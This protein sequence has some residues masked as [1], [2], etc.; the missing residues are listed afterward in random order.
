MRKIGFCGPIV[1]SA[2]AWCFA[3]ASENCVLLRQGFGA[4]SKKISPSS[5]NKRMKPLIFISALFLF[6]CSAEED[7][8]IAISD[9]LKWLPFDEEIYFRAKDESKF[10]LL[11]LGANWCHWCHVMDEKTYA[12]TEVIKFLNA[13][14][15]TAREDQ[16]SRPDLYAA[17]RSYGWPATIVFN[18]EGEELLKLRGYQASDK[19]IRQ[20]QAVIDK[21]VPLTEDAS[22]TATFT[23]GYLNSEELL[24]KYIGN[25]NYEI[26]GYKSA[27]MQ[28]HKEGLEVGLLHSDPQSLVGDWTDMT[29]RNSLE[30]VDPVW[31][32]VSQYS[33]SWNW[34][35]PH[36][37]KLLRIQ[38]Q[39]I[40]AYCRYGVVRNDSTA[41]ATAKKILGYCD[42]FLLQDSKLFANSQNADLEN[43][44]QAFDYYQMGE[45]ERAKVGF[46]SV[47]A[48]HYLKENALMVTALIDLWAATGKEEYLNRSLEMLKIFEADFRNKDASYSRSVI[49]R[50]GQIGILSMEDNRETLR[51]NLRA[52]E[53]T[54]N[55]LY[56]EE[57]SDIAKMLLDKFRDQ[58]GLML[59]FQNSDVIKPKPV[60]EDNLKFCLDLM[61]LAHYSKKDSAAFVTASEEIFSKLPLAE[62]QNKMR[63]MPYVIELLRYR[64]TEPIHA[65]WLCSESD[66]D[67]LREASC[68]KKIVRKLMLHRDP[69]LVIVR[70]DLKNLSE[71]DEKLYGGKENGTLFMCTS[72]F[73]SPPIRTF[74][75]LDE[76]LEK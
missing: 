52:Y 50:T 67:P 28:L 64:E 13:H 42:R 21:P 44:E 14:F 39:Y 71:E 23:T 12:D 68:E 47:D 53:A 76:F 48:N 69:W 15:V 16:D 40:S 11:D 56:L 55:I 66:G 19:F 73:C 27:K 60:T 70:K 34:K 59:P 17:Y 61:K 33:D 6:S 38:A 63:M 24:R 54:G 31:G 49:L 72:T 62:M 4:R 37:E 29:Y 57:A 32:G 75:E 65:V 22:D 46:P 51:A 9:E 2:T 58:N 5:S 18:E 1:D 43:G 3:K 7:K 30:L 45:A 26:G 25:L 20:L 36:Y 74:K 41:I 10:V 8:D 35:N